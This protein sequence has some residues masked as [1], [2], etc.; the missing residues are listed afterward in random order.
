MLEKATGKLY[1][2]NAAGA[3]TGY[4]QNLNTQ[5]VPFVWNSFSYYG[6]GAEITEWGVDTLTAGFNAPIVATK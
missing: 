6:L 5:Y 1:V 3:G 2:P 4:Y